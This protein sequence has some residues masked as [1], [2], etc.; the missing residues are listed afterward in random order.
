MINNTKTLF[1]YTANIPLY[2]Q[3][4]VND[5][6]PHTLGRTWDETSNLAH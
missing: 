2:V 3:T 6:T 1:P 5:K 4:V